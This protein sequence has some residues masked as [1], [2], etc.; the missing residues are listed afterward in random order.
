MMI[1]IGGHELMILIGL[2]LAIIVGILFTRWFRNA[3]AKTVKAALKEDMPKSRPEN[4]DISAAEDSGPIRAEPVSMVQ[5]DE[6]IDSSVPEYDMWLV[7]DGGYM[8]GRIYPITAEK[9]ITFGRLPGNLLQFPADYLGVS[10]EHARLSWK[11]GKLLLEDL[12]STDG[13]VIFGKGQLTP[14]TPQE[15]MPGDVFYIGTEE[16]AFEIR[17]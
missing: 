12:N 17:N 10:R 8:N 5:K 3:M 16:N 14:M 13:T 7:C 6:E 15:V 1:P 11:N 9:P 4:A 2:I